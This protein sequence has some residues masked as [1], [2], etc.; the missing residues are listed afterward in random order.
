MKADDKNSTVFH[1]LGTL[2]EL[3]SYI[4]L[5]KARLENEKN[6]K[7][8]ETIQLNLMKLMSHVSDS[9]NPQYF[10]TESET[11]ELEKEIERL[12]KNLPV[13]NKFILPGKNE[14]EAFIHIARTVARRAERYFAAYNKEKKLCPFAA[15][16][17]NK[18]SNYLFQ[19]TV[20][21]Q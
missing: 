10:F 16:Y 14:T 12:K 2:D 15:K 20:N 21:E 18:L 13:Q 1:L 4:G 6:K 17:I 9:S 7:N 5:V 11:L 3:N 19:L 8:A